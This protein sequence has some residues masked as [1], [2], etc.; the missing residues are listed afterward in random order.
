MQAKSFSNKPIKYKVT[1]ETG[2]PSDAFAVR[3]PESGW[4]FL[5]KRLDY[6]DFSQPKTY[7]LQ[8]H[9]EEEGSGGLSSSTL[10]GVAISDVL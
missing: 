6:D 5:L 10:V 3:Q 8:A 7:R 9:A 2:Q 4:V 1:T